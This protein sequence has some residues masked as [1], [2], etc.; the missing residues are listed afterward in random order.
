MYGVEGYEP[1]IF[2]SDI[3]QK[4]LKLINNQQKPIKLKFIF[5]CEFIKENPATGQIDESLGYFHSL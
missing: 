2:I 4:V 1:K 3:K 5:T